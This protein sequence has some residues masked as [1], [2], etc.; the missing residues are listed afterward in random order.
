MSLGD[1]NFLFL[2]FFIIFLSIV[3]N[4]IRHKVMWSRQNQTE[5]ILTIYLMVELVFVAKNSDEFCLGV[6]G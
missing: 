5:N 3:V 4:V 6:K 2:L 1:L